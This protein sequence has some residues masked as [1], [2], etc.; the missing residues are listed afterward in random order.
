MVVKCGSVKADTSSV[1][2]ARHGKLL[3]PVMLSLRLRFKTVRAGAPTHS[4]ATPS[5]GSVQEAPVKKR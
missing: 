1:A 2:F 5:S 3:K 4:T